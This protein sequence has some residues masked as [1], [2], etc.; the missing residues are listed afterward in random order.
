MPQEPQ[1]ADRI[2][3]TAMMLAEQSSWESLHL[4]HI[5]QHLGI[6]LTD[7]YH[8]Y[9]VK[10]E[11]VEAWYSCADRRM[12]QCTDEAG[13][14]QLT[15]RQRL[16]VLIGAWLDC[17]AEHKQVSYDMLW[18]KLEPAHVHLQ[19]QGLLRISMTVQWIRDAARI[20]STHLRRI[21]EELG[22]TQ[23]FLN[24]FLYWMFDSSPHQR[25]TRQFLDRRLQRA[26]WLYNKA[27]PLRR[28]RGRGIGHVTTS[29]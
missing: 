5:A 24:T 16:A 17:L 13:F 12:L 10:D 9:T 14:Y 21:A 28:A 20:D 11:L 29:R 7:I 19:V 22:L 18:Y 23:V 1:P 4:H 15:V 25:N 27:W 26:E 8:H 2:L 3:S 6:P